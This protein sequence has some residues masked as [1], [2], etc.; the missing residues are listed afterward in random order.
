MEIYVLYIIN[1][2]I[3][4]NKEMDDIEIE[5]YSILQVSIQVVFVCLGGLYKY[6]SLYQ[7]VI[8]Y[9]VQILIIIWYLFYFIDLQKMYKNRKFK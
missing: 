6:V 2:I 7:V 9:K 5:G 8:M 1:K 4:C 3:L